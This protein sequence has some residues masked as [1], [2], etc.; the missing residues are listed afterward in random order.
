MAK[1]DAAARVELRGRCAEDVLF[2]LN[3]FGWVYEPRESE[4]AVLPMVTWALASRRQ[5]TASLS[6]MARAG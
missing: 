5:V 4:G 1:E 3:V 2:F 6:S